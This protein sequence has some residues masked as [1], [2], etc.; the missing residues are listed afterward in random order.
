LLSSS[1]NHSSDELEEDE[2]VL[3]ATREVIS[4][5]VPPE[6]ELGASG[7]EDAVVDKAVYLYI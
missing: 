5:E 1:L 4:L 3:S 7:P 2:S 6:E